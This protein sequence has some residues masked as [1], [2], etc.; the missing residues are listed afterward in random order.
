MKIFIKIIVLIAIG[1]IIIGCEEYTITITNRHV[2]GDVKINGF[3]Q[4]GQ[5]LSVTGEGDFLNVPYQ[6]VNDDGEFIYSYV[7]RRIIPSNSSQST[8]STES[9]Y[10]VKPEDEGLTIVAHIFCPCKEVSIPTAPTSRV[11][12]FTTP[13]PGL[14]FKMINN[15]SGYSVYKGTAGAHF[16]LIPPFH[17]DIP[18]IE[19]AF[20]GFT[21]YESLTT[22]ILPSGL[23]KID[24][25]G[26]YFC[27]NLENIVM[28]AGMKHIEAHAFNECNKLSNIFYMGTASEWDG[29]NI[30]PQNGRLNHSD[31]ER[32]AKVYYHSETSTGSGTHWRLVNGVPTIWE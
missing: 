29:I 22:V 23:T 2:D 32:K 3:A 19:I 26:F 31:P 24:E 15:N 20:R 7:W 16:V 30:G 17:R 28:P 27:V 8:V 4:V 5:T 25:Y 14:I 1:L 6:C 21:N 9:T 18:I 11:I 12:G 10:T 13:A